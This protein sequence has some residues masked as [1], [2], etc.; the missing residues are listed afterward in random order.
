MLAGGTANEAWAAKVTYHIL[1]LPIDNTIY[2]MK[3]GVNGKRLEAVKIIVDKQTT[4]ELPAHYKSPLAENFKYYE[5]KDI[6]GHGGSAVS[7]YEDVASRKGVLYE[8]KASPT[9]VAEGTAITGSTA[10]Y[11]VVYTYKT[12]NTIA[13]LDGTVNYN[14]GVKGK[15]FLSLNRGRN[16]RP[17]VIPTAKV[18]AVMLASEDFSY[19][20]NPGNSV[21]T[22]W[23]SG[24]NKNNQS[25]VE[26]QF[27][28]GFKFEGNDPYHIIVRTS[29]ARDYTFIEKNEDGDKAF[30]YKW[31]KGAALMAKTTGN[32]YLASDDHIRYKTVYNSAIPNPTDLSSGYDSKTGYF[33][34]NDQTWGTVALLNNTAGDGYVFMGSRTVD[35]NG[36]VP[37]PK[38]NTKYYYLTFNGYNNLNFGQITSADA[39]KSH[40][41]DG[42][43]PLKKV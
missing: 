22:Y 14:I 4:V 27:F 11:Y 1:T 8:V 35:G 40:T 6:T 32:A 25:D 13:K 9:P 38:D 41:V 15:G 10:E 18:D 26:S 36:N 33:H 37:G 29:Y 34:G 30:V 2:K 31:Y 5:T 42:I 20:D 24:D 17:A 16:N 7:L 19:V 21:G 12:S 3:S 23:S 43:Y 28:F 39:T